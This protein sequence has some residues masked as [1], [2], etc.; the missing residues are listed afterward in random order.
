M[1]VFVLPLMLRY[2]GE[3]GP[4]LK[5]FFYWFYPAHTA[6]LFLLARALL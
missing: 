2:N 1:R 5:W 4:G 6:A 3:R